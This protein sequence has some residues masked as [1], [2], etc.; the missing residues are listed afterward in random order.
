MQRNPD[1]LDIDDIDPFSFRYLHER[2]LYHSRSS[3]EHAIDQFVQDLCN[4][5]RKDYG[6]ERRLQI[7]KMCKRFITKIVYQWMEYDA[8]GFGFLQKVDGV[9]RKTPEFEAAWGARR[10]EWVDK[11]HHGLRDGIIE[12]H[13]VTCSYSVSKRRVGYF[14]LL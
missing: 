14:L 11:V 8:G 10:K 3:N 12:M 5:F 2:G 7:K 9:V 4:Y 6:Q 1:H 13:H